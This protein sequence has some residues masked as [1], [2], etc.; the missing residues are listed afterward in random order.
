[1][2]GPDRLELTMKSVQEQFSDYAAFHRTPGNK[3]FHRLGIP[4]IMLSLM[5]MLERVA[6]FHSEGWQLDL[7]AILIVGSG[8]YYLAL[9]W[10][11]GIAM[12]AVSIVM[13]FAG[14]A[15]PMWLLVILFVT[16]WIFQGIGHA[17][18]EKRQPAFAQN[19]VHL[20]IG[21]LWILNDAIGVVREPSR[22]TT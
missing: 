11:L 10:R 1:M 6:L 17:V 19:L 2:I 21:P 5:G 14:A 8:I 9:E 3:L 20:L 7:A 12:I 15:M 18:Y 13:Y 22:V 16:G 4:I